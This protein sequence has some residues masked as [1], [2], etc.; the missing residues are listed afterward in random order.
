MPQNTTLRLPESQW[1]EITATD[2]TRCTFQNTGV[3]PVFIA[4][5]AGAAPT[6]TETSL[7]YAAGQG[8]RNVELS[9]LFP[10]VAAVRLW[11]YSPQSSGQVFISHA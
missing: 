1:T 7:R 11:A 10:G 3:F 8:E 6:D 5:T 4:G 2:V 9:D